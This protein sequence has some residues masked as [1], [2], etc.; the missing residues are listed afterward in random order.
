MG[1]RCATLD[2]GNHHTAGKVPQPREDS[3]R[4]RQASDGVQSE[5]NVSHA[6]PTGAG[7]LTAREFDSPSGVAT[8]AGQ[9]TAKR[10]A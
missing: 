6:R 2:D 5:D 8:F 9:R 1:G 3:A 10:N 7:A 4:S